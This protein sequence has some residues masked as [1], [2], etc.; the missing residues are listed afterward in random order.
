[1]FKQNSGEKTPKT[2][3]NYKPPLRPTFPAS[4]TGQLHQLHSSRRPWTALLILWAETVRTSRSTLPKLK[5]GTTNLL[6]SLEYDL[7]HLFLNIDNVSDVRILPET[8]L[9]QEIH[10]H[11]ITV[12]AFIERWLKASL[13]RRPFNSNARNRW[14]TR[15]KSYEENM[16]MIRMTCLECNKWPK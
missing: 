12:F 2:E 8:L 11:N 9:C 1:M 15:V 10:S 14:T 6:L 3:E 13:E 5:T 4:L 7:V 16:S